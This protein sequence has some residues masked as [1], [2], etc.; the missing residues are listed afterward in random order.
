MRDRANAIRHLRYAIDRL[1]VKTRIAM[2]EGIRSNEII[3]GAYVDRRGGVCPMLAAHRQGSRTTV[4][5]FARAWDGFTGARRARRATQREVGILVSHLEASLLAD[6]HVDLAAAIAEHR[7]LVGRRETIPAAASHGREERRA[8]PVVSSG[9]AWLRPFRRLDD[10][11]RALERLEAETCAIEDHRDP[12]G[13]ET[14]R[15]RVL[16]SR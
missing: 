1:P 14:A 10:Y 12:S 16:I 9:R 8:E 15:E 7:E 5:P 13:G 3:A 2:L 6:E 11:Q 4:L